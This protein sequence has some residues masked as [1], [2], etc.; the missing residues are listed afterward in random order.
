M[1]IFHDCLLSHFCSFPLWGKAGMGASGGKFPLA[2]LAPRIQRQPGAD[3]WLCLMMVL[4]CGNLRNLW[5]KTLP[6]IAQLHRF[7]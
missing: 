4:I 1:S 3:D 7:T 6:Q 2:E 5:I